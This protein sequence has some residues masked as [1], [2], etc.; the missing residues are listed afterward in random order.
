MQNIK[1][2]NIKKILITGGA[3]YIG[4]ILSTVLLDN[5][6]KVTVIDNLKYS[7]DS[8]DH[9][10]ANKDF[11]L[12]ISD[13]RDT[14]VLKKIINKFDIIIP[15]AALVGAPL[16]DKFPKLAK[17]LNE[18]HISFILDNIGKKQK[19]IYLNSNSGYGIGKKNKFCDEKSPLKPISLYGRTKVNSEKKVIKLNNYIIFRL[20]TVFGYSYRMRTDLLL[21]NLVYHSLKHKIIEIYEPN[22]RRNFIHVRDVC[23]AILFSIKNFNKLKNNIYNLGLSS[24]NITKLQM[25]KKINKYNRNFKYKIVKN[26]K[27]IDKRD[28]FVSNKKIESKGFKARISLDDGINELLKIFTKNM[29]I[30][31]NNY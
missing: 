30:Y 5:G 22:F 25:I 4:S 20:A 15:L 26:Q 28:Y 7:K 19:I 31:K 3:G 10:M 16:C 1:L 9:L 11:N 13:V 21:N 23:Y 18:D 27:D 12:I 24:G 14:K 6:Y 29:K 8:L 2:R 17:E